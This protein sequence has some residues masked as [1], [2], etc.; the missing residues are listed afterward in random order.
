MLI[1]SHS[2][3][4]DAINAI[5][6]EG[7]TSQTAV[8]EEE[9]VSQTRLQLTAAL[10]IYFPIDESD[11]RLRDQKVLMVA[12]DSGTVTSLTGTPSEMALNLSLIE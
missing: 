10:F 11:E 4:L 2:S 12:K 1:E 6:K 8:R 7:Q 9:A 3:A 5:E